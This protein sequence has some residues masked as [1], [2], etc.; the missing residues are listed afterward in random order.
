MSVKLFKT[1]HIKKN[2]CKIPYLITFFSTAKKRKE[3]IQ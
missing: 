2:H 3:K 1:S